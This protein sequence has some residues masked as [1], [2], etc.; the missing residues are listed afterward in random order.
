[1]K[2]KTRISVLCLLVMM[3]CSVSVALAQHRNTAKMTLNCSIPAIALLDFSAPE[4]RTISF[5]NSSEA[6]SIEQVITRSTGDNTWI[7]Y[8][9]IVRPGLTNYITVEISTGYLPSDVDLL[10]YVSQDNGAGSGT[11]GTAC[12]V[13]KL[14]YSPQVI[15]SNIGSCY[16]GKG[17]Y[18]GHRLRYEW[19]NGESYNHSLMTDQSNIISVTYTISSTE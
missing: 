9:S 3:I 4:I 18:K 14:N 15:I 2:H 17:M 7:N 8:S 12:G 13:I 11:L 1:M 6:N 19:K 16:T 5:G 10:L